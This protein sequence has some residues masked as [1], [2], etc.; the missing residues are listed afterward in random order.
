MRLYCYVDVRVKDVN[1]FV[2]VVVVVGGGVA[3]CLPPSL[4]IKIKRLA[5]FSPVF[6]CFDCFPIIKKQKQHKKNNYSTKTKLL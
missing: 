4:T 1:N 3:F 6:D 5:S 2:V